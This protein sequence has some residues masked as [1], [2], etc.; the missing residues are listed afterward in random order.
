MDLAYSYDHLNS[1]SRSTTPT[2]ATN[3]NNQPTP[4]DEPPTPKAERQTLQTE[5]QETFRAFSASPWGAKLG[6][7]WGNVRKQSEAAYEEAVR[8]AEAA[9]VDAVKGWSGIVGRVRGMS[10]GE[11]DTPKQ[12]EDEKE[13]EREER[14]EVGASTPVAVPGEEPLPNT[15]ANKGEEGDV[16]HDTENLLSRFRAEA[17]KRLKD[18]QKAEDAADEALLRFGTTVRNF[19]RDA[20]VITPAED[21]QQPGE[22]LFES[23]DG[24]GKRTIHTSRMDA[25]LHAIHTNTASFMAD[26]EGSEWDD[27]KGGF[28]VEKKTEE[29]AKDLERYPELRRTMEGCVPEKVEYAEFWRRYYFL[30]RVVEVQEEKRKELLKGKTSSRVDDVPANDV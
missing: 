18:V 13:R 16:L 29:I 12:T 28:D 17:A 22:V 6:G 2:P 23:K 26:P 25:Q 8:E 5:F 20:V 9:R 10:L 1:P 11:E 21:E 4:S 24:A 15:G 7:I 27:F 19:L 3:P 30:R 14:P